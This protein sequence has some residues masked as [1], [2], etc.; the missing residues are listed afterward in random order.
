MSAIAWEQLF[1]FFLVLT[2]QPV[3]DVGIP[4]KYQRCDN[5]AL[6]LKSF[7]CMRTEKMDL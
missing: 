7:S 4:T 3:Y 1:S 2:F 6:F 5:N